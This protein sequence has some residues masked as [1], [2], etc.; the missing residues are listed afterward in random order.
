[1][2][3]N[4]LA[5]DIAP[6]PTTRAEIGTARSVRQE[7]AITGHHPYSLAARLFLPAFAWH[8]PRPTLVADRSGHVTFI[9]LQVPFGSPTTDKASLATSLT[10][11]GLLTPVSPGTLPVLLRSRVVLLYRAVRKHLGAV[12]E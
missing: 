5:V 3:M 6:S 7:L 8:L 11:I 12:G 4:A 10:L 9:T 1:M 2:S